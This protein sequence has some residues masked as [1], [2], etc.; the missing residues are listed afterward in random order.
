MDMAFFGA[1]LSR[2]E[3]VLAHESGTI[4]CS[5]STGSGG[6][7]VIQPDGTTSR[8]LSTG[9]AIVP[10]GI[11]LQADGSFLIAHL[12]TEDGG[13]FR[14]WADGTL[15]PFLVEL[16]GRPLAPSNF[17]HR[18]ALDRLWIC[19]STELRPR[20]LDYR[21]EL[22]DGVIILVDKAGARVVA[23]GLGY[24]NECVVDLEKGRLYVNETFGRRLTGFTIRPDGA[25][26]DRRVVTTFGAGDFPDGLSLDVDDGLWVTSV[27]S[28]RLIRV[29]PQG[30]QE[31][32]LEQSDPAAV[33][34][35]EEAFAAGRMHKDDLASTME[36]G[37]RNLSSLAFCG[38]DMKTGLLGSLGNDAL[39]KIRLPVAGRK[40][41]HWSQALP[42]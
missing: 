41:A 35:V 22:A 25:L 31:V 17:V 11:A 18:D 5:D 15:E 38:P 42:V 4:F 36:T 6:V 26:A 27:V 37:L 3:C 1:N 8:I 21:A 14:L 7:S 24:T 32:V 40:P 10:N 33:A 2:P 12:G 20:H 13:I 23:E 29:D 28:N 30:R 19:V 16:G 34:R 39:V 9:R